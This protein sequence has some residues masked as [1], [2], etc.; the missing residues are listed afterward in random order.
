MIIDQDIL[1]DFTAEAKEKLRLRMTL[2][3][4]GLYRISHI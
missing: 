2:C 4:H 1:D 3:T